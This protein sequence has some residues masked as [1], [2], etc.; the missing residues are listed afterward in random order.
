M[1]HASFVRLWP[2]A[3]LHQR[4][5]GQALYGRT[6]I[7][8]LVCLVRD[9]A[10]GLETDGEHKSTTDFVEIDTISAHSI[11]ANVFSWV[12]NSVNLWSLRAAKQI[13]GQQNCQR[14][15]KTGVNGKLIW[16]ACRSKCARATKDASAVLFLPNVTERPPPP[17]LLR[18]FSCA[19]QLA[20]FV[21]GG[22]N[23][24]TQCQIWQ[25][26]R[27]GVRTLHGTT[28]LESVGRKECS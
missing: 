3:N 4:V 19:V 11:Y 24:I 26:L 23:N 1:A 9:K 22:L 5:E 12:L 6:N 20:K 16:K 7:L 25:Y 17:P 21:F 10:S 14:I 2:Q 27:R 13:R 15:S 28:N 18:L 8:V